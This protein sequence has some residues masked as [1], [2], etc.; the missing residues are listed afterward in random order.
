[1]G[2]DH[3][4]RVTLG[5]VGE[6]V[7]ATPLAGGAGVLMSLVKAD[8]VAAVPR[9]SEGYQPGDDGAGGAAAPARGASTAPSSPS[10]ATT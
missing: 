1:M 9:F 3:F 2:E 6:R 10:A 4:V 5:K 8:G 7:V